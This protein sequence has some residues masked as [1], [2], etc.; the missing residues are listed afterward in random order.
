MDLDT[1]AAFSAFTKATN[2][3]NYWRMQAY[4]RL[5]KLGLDDS[6]FKRLE[7]QAETWSAIATYCFTL[8][9]GDWT[10]PE[11]VTPEHV[12]LGNELIAAEQ[13]LI[14]RIDSGLTC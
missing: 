9:V 10:M 3:A 14:I 5:D 13:D 6:T 7:D 11:E 2:N 1:Q 8:A 4:N 12:L